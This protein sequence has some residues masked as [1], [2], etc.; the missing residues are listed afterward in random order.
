M[1]Q[2]SY[3]PVYRFFAK[4]EKTEIPMPENYWTQTGDVMLRFDTDEYGR[5]SVIGNYTVFV[6]NKE[7]RWGYDESE[8]IPAF[9]QQIGV[10]VLGRIPL[11]SISSMMK[12]GGG[13]F[14]REKEPL[15]FGTSANVYQE[16]MVREVRG[17]AEEDVLACL[18]VLAQA[19]YRWNVL[20]A[21][22]VE[23][24]VDG[25]FYED[26]GQWKWIAGGGVDIH[27]K[28]NKQQGLVVEY[29]YPFVQI[30]QTQR[31]GMIVMGFVWIFGGEQ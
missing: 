1:W 18:G 2:V 15:L 5:W 28:W 26:G 7:Y 14:W 8:R 6:R 19:S 20:Q 29:N 23:L 25:L 24:G 21:I 10:H 13:F 3:I 31:F 11:E 4:A 30:Q 27:W 9:D 17:Y 12:V 22:G 16:E